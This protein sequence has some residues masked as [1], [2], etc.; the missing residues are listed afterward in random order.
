MIAGQSNRQSHKNGK[1]AAWLRRRVLSTRV[2]SVASSSDSGAGDDPSCVLCGQ[3]YMRKDTAE[4][5][6]ENFFVL[7]KSP[8]VLA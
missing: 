4:P 5:L 1:F 3:L 8:A 7:R 6:E 2:G